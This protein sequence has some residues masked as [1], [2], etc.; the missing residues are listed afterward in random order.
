MKALARFSQ[1]E[2]LPLL[3]ELAE[4]EYPDVLVEAVRG[5]ASFWFR[6]ELEAFLNQ[7]DQYELCLP[8]TNCSICPSG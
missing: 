3:R 4:D 5:L 8:W 7:H 1:T 6:E 2:N